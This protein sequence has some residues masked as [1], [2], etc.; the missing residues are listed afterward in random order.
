MDRKM[1]D[2]V[3]VSFGHNIFNLLPEFVV[4]YTVYEKIYVN[5]KW[6]K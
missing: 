6:K 4:V 5:E 1:T 2:W 3:L